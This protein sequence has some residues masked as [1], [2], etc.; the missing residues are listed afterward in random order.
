LNHLVG[1]EFHV[2]DVKIRGIR[3]CEPCDHLQRLTGASVIKGLL[4]RG[5]LRA[6]ILSKGRI[7]VGDVVSE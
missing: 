6:Q 2:G 5:G 3:L 4:H 7:R 1:R